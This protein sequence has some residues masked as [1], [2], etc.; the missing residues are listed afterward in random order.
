MG[1]DGDWAF[2]ATKEVPWGCLGGGEIGANLWGIAPLFARNLRRFKSLA[3]IN[4]YFNGLPPGLQRWDAC[5]THSQVFPGVDVFLSGMG[6][7]KGA[8][9]NLL[10]NRW[11]YIGLS[12]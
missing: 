4:F 1:A 9:P 2:T 7:T 12:A 3:G 10:T 5:R 11:V 6:P 8:D